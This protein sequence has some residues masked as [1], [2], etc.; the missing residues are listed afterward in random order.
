MI[1]LPI[2]L[3]FLSCLYGSELASL[4]NTETETGG[5]VTIRLKKS[6]YDRYTTI[7]NEYKLVSNKT[8]PLGEM[9]DIMFTDLCDELEIIVN[10][11][12]DK[13]K[14]QSSKA[15]QVQKETQK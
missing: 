6:V 9:G 13:E 8:L 4:L 10:A 12:K 2:I 7:R 15:I 11:L 5:S 1:T 3:S 14:K